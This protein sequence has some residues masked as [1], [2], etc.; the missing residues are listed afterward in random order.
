MPRSEGGRQTGETVRRSLPFG[1]NAWVPYAL[2]LLPGVLS[3]A[4]VHAFG[5]NV[6]FRDQWE[7][8]RY[9]EQLSNSNLSFSAVWE[10]HNEHRFFFPRIAMLALG[11]ITEWNNVAEMYLIQLCLFATL[12]GLWLAFGT[13]SRSGPLLF[14]PV[15]FMVFTLSQSQNMLWG[16]QITFAFTQTFSVLALLFLHLSGR[17][18]KWK[19][20]FPIA[21][22]SG[23]VAAFSAIQGLL[24]WPAG[25]LQILIAPLEKRVKGI[26]IA[27]W[28]STGTVVWVA[29]FVDYEPDVVSSPFGLLTNPVAGVGRFLSLLGDSL[30]LG[31]VPFLTQRD[32]A[33]ANGLLVLG[34]AVTALLLVYKY[35]E[36]GKY[37]FWLSLLAFSFLV[38]LSM[39][40]GRSESGG[41]SVSASRY[42]TFSVLA[43][44][45]V[46]A[47]LVKLWTERKTRFTTALLGIFLTLILLNIPFSYLRG[48]GTGVAIRTDRE[49]AA[50]VLRTYESQ[51]NESLR[52]LRRSPESVRRLAS[53]LEDLGYNVFSEPQARP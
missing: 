53:V 29:Y 42:V 14:V 44:I 43:A 8:V 13:G 15:A 2:I 24:V 45:G 20:T 39:T 41:D 19:F 23:T 12:A 33:F 35:A 6:V 40:L 52:T 21:L 26:L 16:Y 38:L 49:E 28:G 1:A 47:M 30:Y 4:Y 46:Y 5:V 48:I 31:Y 17:G 25:L 34:L 27:A 37:S 50:F 10:P 32:F 18:G 22:T 11:T 36:L 51:S 9:F 3:V 7:M